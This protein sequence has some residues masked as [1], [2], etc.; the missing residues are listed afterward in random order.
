MKAPPGFTVQLDS[1]TEAPAPARLHG[2]AGIH[3]LAIA[4]PDRP[5][6]RRDVRLDPGKPLA[7]VLK[8]EPVQNTHSSHAPTEPNAQEPVKDATQ[9]AAPAPRSTAEAPHA[10]PGQFRR[11]IGFAA[12]GFGAASLGATILLG[13]ETVNARNA[14][15]ATPTHPLYDHEQT[16]QTATNVALVGGAVLLAG[17]IVLVLWPAGSS[18]GEV[19][20]GIAPAPGGGSLVGSF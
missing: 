11:S 2:V 17:G 14:Y 13:V 15:N 12:I 9:P 8:D 3:S 7:L 20:V 6:A 19:T 5:I 16:L 1:G 4:A 10:A 18:S